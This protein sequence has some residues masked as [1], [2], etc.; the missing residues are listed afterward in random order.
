MASD[1]TS[2]QAPSV[3]AGFR[4]QILQSIM[5]LIDLARDG[6]LLLEVSEDF[7]VIADGVQTDVQVKGSQAEAG[8]P[9]YSLRTRSIRDV[10]IRF[11]N[12]A[13]TASGASRDLAFM[14]RGH[15]AVERGFSLPDG[16]SGIAYWRAAALDAD[17][18]PLRA[19]LVTLLAGSELGDWL[20]SSPTDTELRDRLLRRVSW[21]LEELPADALY[22]EALDRLRRLYF[23]MN[24]PVAAADQAMSGLIDLVFKCASRPVEA[25]RRL[26]RI[27]LELELQKVAGRLMVIQRMQSQP[28]AVEDLLISE[29]APPEVVALRASTVEGIVEGAQGQPLIWLCGSHG[30]GKSTLARLA[31]ANMGGKWLV[32]D[33]W[34]I[35]GDGV[36]TLAA[37]RALTRRVAI[38]DLAGVILDNL[39]DVAGETILERLGPFLRSFGARGGRVIASSHRQPSPA[40]LVLVGSGA[41][42]IQAPYFS[43]ADIVELVSAHP[44]PHADTINA[45]AMMIGVGSSGGHPTLV[46]A[47]VASLRARGWPKDALL[48]DLTEV[49]EAKSLTQESARRKLLRSLKE[50]DAARSLEAGQ[51]LR[52]IASVFDRVDEPLA[53]KLAAQDPVLPNAGDAL[54]ALKGSWLE[55]LPLGDLRV[56]PLIADIA[57]DVPNAMSLHCK[58]VAAVHWISRRTLDERTLPLCFWNAYLGEHDWVLMKISETMQ[59]MDADKFSAAAPMLSPLTALVTDKPL[60]SGEPVTAAFVRVLQFRVAVALGN[61]GAARKSAD[62]LLV[63]LRELDDLPRALMTTTCALQVLLSDADLNVSQRLEFALRL[64]EEYPNAERLTDNHLENPRRLLPPQLRDDMDTSDFLVTRVV[65]MT[66][67]TEKFK[68]VVSAMGALRQDDRDRF[69]DAISIMYGGLSVFASSG[70][71]GDQ[72]AGREMEMVLRDYGQVDLAVQSWDRPDLQIEMVISRSVIL[73]ESLSRQPEALQVVEDAIKAYGEEPPLLRQKA[74][75]F[76]HMGRHS[77]ATDLTL[78]IEDTIALGDNLERTLALRDG[79][80]SAGKDGRFDQAERLFEKARQTLTDTDDHVPLRV[81]LVIERSLSLWRGGKHLDA[82][83]LAA[84]ILEQLE[85]TNANMSRQAERTHQYG[86]AIIGLFHQEPARLPRVEQPP[87]DFGHASQLELSDAALLNAPLASLADNWRILASVAADFGEFNE[88]DRLSMAK[89]DDTLS[90]LLERAILASRYGTAVSAGDVSAALGIIAGLRRVTEIIRIHGASDRAPRHL[91]KVDLAEFSVEANSEYLSLALL[92]LISYRVV[93]G[94][95]DQ[96]FIRRIG[97][98][99]EEV[100]GGVTLASPVLD[101]ATQLHA[102]DP[103][104]RYTFLAKGITQHIGR[105]TQSPEVRLHRDVALLAHVRFSLLRPELIPAAADLIVR[106]WRQVA[107]SSPADMKAALDDA[108]ASTGSSI[109]IAVAVLVAASLHVPHRFADQWF[110]LDGL[111]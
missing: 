16:L 104:S 64:R 3:I 57:R 22:G 86:R 14:A 5:A 10:L 83:S 38:E 54:A 97:N 74:R 1:E 55:V 12:A 66:R 68:E 95:Y 56:S 29:M 99:M 2:G 41:P 53:L 21:Q 109:S 43:Q 19:M 87:F 103:S 27:D 59:S 60:Y 93:N 25:D 58:R 100:F 105:V 51:L 44:A 111:E 26:G 85:T 88:I 20:A 82:I 45:W 24:L 48:E 62:R 40:E 73:D 94:T 84:E 18:A 35:K 70:W 92:D 63:E 102:V 101:A 28:V 91:F 47:K 32:L 52:R 31:A 33:T 42:P 9:S 4:Y 106:G 90:T 23:D 37:W 15:E 61:N 13:E 75:V 71:S 108:F 67:S 65:G 8:P 77:E 110:A 6:E 11:W 17:T 79:A 81:A 34:P 98:A 78:A 36:A 39:I 46:A 69:L 96:S 89:Q 30:T 49:S 7:S 107:D 72:M 80:V 50:M 76:G